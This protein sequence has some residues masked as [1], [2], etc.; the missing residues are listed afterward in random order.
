MTTPQSFPASFPHSEKKDNLRAWTV[1]S[2]R[3][4]FFF[5]RDSPSLNA[6][7]F[8]QVSG[9]TEEKRKKPQ[10]LNTGPPE[11]TTEGLFDVQVTVHR[12]TF[13]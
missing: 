13:L 7:I 4:T 1:Y 12:D 9:R 11:Q 6:S 5:G 3:I 10:Y 2:T 8:Q